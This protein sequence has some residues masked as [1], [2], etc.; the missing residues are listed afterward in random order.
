VSPA[1]PRIGVRLPQY[2]ASW[3]ELREAAVR[4]EELG[5]A[6]LWLNDHLQSPGRRKDEAA[7]D[8][9]TGLAAL[10]PLTSRARLG[11]AVLSAS[12]RPPA[13]A[14]KMATVL[15]VI[16]GGRVTLGLGSGSDRPEHRAYGIP[17]A[18][19]P[20]RVAAAR[21][22]LRTMRAM[23]DRPEGAS[24]DGVLENAP[25][26]PPPV[27][28][29]GPPIWLAAHR[30]RLLRLAG[31]EA[32][33]IVAAFVGPEEVARRLARADEA[34]E[35][36]GRPALSCA[37]YT[38]ALP[39]ASQEEAASWLGRE[40]ESLGTAPAK[41]VRW[42]RTTGIVG[43]PDEVRDA[44]AAYAAAGVTD[45]ILVLPNRVPLEAFAALAEAVLPGGSS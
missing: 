12:Y 28:P 8:A 9:L 34:R 20:E 37:L 3:D 10:A 43:S 35:A 24:L 32:D 30:P 4:C 1:A 13:L 5:F 19:P 42:L 45:A 16:S 25:N 44:L 41:L 7:F 23:F 27:Q 17:F 21:T 38:Y 15:D 11:V 39:M 22:A 29:G 36:A 33:G 31:G 2:G 14:A 18:S 6:G 26:L 40:A